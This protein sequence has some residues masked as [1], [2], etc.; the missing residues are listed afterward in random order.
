M[1]MHTVKVVDPAAALD[2]RSPEHHQDRAQQQDRRR[3][4]SEADGV[5]EQQHQ[6]DSADDHGRRGR[7]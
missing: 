2:E 4:T 1:G 6:R 3:P 5:S 7:L